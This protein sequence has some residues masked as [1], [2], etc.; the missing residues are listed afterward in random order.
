MICLIIRLEKATASQM[1]WLR[2]TV[3]AGLP[4]IK[5][6]L[7]VLY[8]SAQY[9]SIHDTLEGY[10]GLLIESDEWRTGKKDFIKHR[11]SSAA[12]SGS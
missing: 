10:E 1:N 3:L 12:F 11:L 9:L 6:K 2:D 5:D 8:A 7:T 4:K